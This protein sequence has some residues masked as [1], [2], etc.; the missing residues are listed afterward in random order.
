MHK[1]ILH[2]S[3]F[4]SRAVARD[5]IF[6]C[7]RFVAALLF[8]AQMIIET[9]QVATFEEILRTSLVRG[10]N[11]HSFV[12]GDSSTAVNARRARVPHGGGAPRH[13]CYCFKRAARPGRAELVTSLPG[14]SVTK[15]SFPVCC[16]SS[17]ACCRGVLRL[18]K[19][20]L[21]RR[22][23]FLSSLGPFRAWGFRNDSPRAS[24]GLFG[25]C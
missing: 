14:G 2:S 3:H 10:C 20:L 11:C 21:S 16:G 9:N 22:S 6:G 17:S 23:V 1:E 12:F 19:R 7:C 18:V 15:G 4:F 25:F 24:P 8:S 5:K 13:N